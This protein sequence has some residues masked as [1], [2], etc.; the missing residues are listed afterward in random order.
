LLLAVMVCIAGASVVDAV[1]P[2][3]NGF[4]EAFAAMLVAVLLLSPLIAWR[5]IRGDGRWTGDGRS[6]IDVEVR[7]ATREAPPEPFRT[8]LA[9]YLHLPEQEVLA[10]R[11]RPAST[12][13]FW[14]LVPLPQRA[15][16]MKSVEFMRAILERI[17]RAVHG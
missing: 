10:P 16:V 11:P 15:T 14:S 2:V 1:V 5:H 13:P 9:G 3:E 4:A 12:M 8:R 17:R 6:P 7:P